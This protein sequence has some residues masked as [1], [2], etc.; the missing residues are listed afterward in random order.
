MSANKPPPVG[1]FMK[2]GHLR[3]EVVDSSTEYVVLRFDGRLRALEHIDGEWRDYDGDVWVVEEQ[4]PP[5]LPV[6]TV[7]MSRLPD[8]L[9]GRFWTLADIDNAANRIEELEA[10]LR[11]TANAVEFEDDRL[12]YVSVQMDRDVWLNYRE[13]QQ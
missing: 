5:T 12:G 3:C 7:L 1:A 13:V 2:W 9:R 4:E 8:I 10:I 6:G 11:E